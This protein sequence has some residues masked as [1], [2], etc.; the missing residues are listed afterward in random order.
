MKA[1]YAEKPMGL[2]IDHRG[3]TL[4]TVTPEAATVRHIISGVEKQVRVSSLP[5]QRAADDMRDRRIGHQLDRFYANVVAALNGAD[6]V[7]ILGPG[8]AK[9]ELAQALAGARHGRQVAQLESA[10]RLTERQ[11][12]ARVRAW[13]QA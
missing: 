5:V 9:R 11:I 2:W 4:V 3:A 12:V 13:A 6:A 8:E 7:L 1:R 10:A